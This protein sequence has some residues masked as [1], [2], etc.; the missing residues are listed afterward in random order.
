MIAGEGLKVLHR[1]FCNIYNKIKNTR[2]NCIMN[3][4]LETLLCLYRVRVVNERDLL[5]YKKF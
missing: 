3:K 1:A 2:P 4:N 5:Y